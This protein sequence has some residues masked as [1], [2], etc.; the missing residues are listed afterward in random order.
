MDEWLNYDRFDRETWHSFFPYGKTFLT[1]ENL[2]DIKSLNDQLPGNDSIILKRHLMQ[3]KVARRI[4]TKQIYH[5]IR[6]DDI[7]LGLAHLVTAL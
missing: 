5:I 7:S 4:Y 6:I 2:D 3:Y 1:Q